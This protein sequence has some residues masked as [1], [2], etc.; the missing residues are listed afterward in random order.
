M[1]VVALISGDP[2][3]E[4]SGRMMVETLQGQLAQ[5]TG[6]AVGWAGPD[7]VQGSGQS[8]V[9]GDVSKSHL[10]KRTGQCGESSGTLW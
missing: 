4:G 9:Y 3:R 10:G 1:L 8:Q 2:G 5:A 6:N 7:K